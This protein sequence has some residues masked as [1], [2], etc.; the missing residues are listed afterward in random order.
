MIRELQFG[1]F[2]DVSRRSLFLLRCVGRVGLDFRFGGR[3]FE[4]RPCINRFFYS[5]NESRSHRNKTFW[6]SRLVD[7]QILL[8][9][10]KSIEI[11][12]YLYNFKM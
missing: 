3:G 4:S 9:F 6:G 11:G 7:F 12:T 8:Y 5:K 10:S 2:H 1:S